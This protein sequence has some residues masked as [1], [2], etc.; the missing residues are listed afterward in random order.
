M[1]KVWSRGKDE[2][3]RVVEIFEFLA[4][5]DKWVKGTRASMLRD[6]TYY[7]IRF[8]EIPAH[9]ACMRECMFVLYACTPAHTNLAH[10]HARTYV[11]MYVCNDVAC[12]T[13][14]RRVSESTAMRRVV[15]WTMARLYVCVTVHTATSIHLTRTYAVTSRHIHPWILRPIYLAEISRVNKSNTS[16]FLTR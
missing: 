14:L 1:K 5:G 3:L 6:Q 7:V 2:I 8:C 4:R 15:W 10:T 13:Q 11:Y 12:F 9:C 16:L